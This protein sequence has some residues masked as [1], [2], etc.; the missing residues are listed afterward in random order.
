MEALLAFLGLSL[1]FF[2]LMCRE[3]KRLEAQRREI[4]VGITADVSD[5][6]L[7]MNRAGE[8]ARRTA[9]A[10]RQFHVQWATEKAIDQ[11]QDALTELEKHD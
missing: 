1:I 8:A 7:A 4:I 2:Y 9:D 5:F 3:Q 10:M 6:T 11:Y